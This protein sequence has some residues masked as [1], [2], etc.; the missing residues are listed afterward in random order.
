MLAPGLD[1]FRA[2]PGSA[3]P[4]LCSRCPR[5]PTYMHAYAESNGV[6]TLLASSSSTF[7]ME[8]RSLRSR[9][10]RT[11]RHP[12]QP[13]WWTRGILSGSGSGSSHLAIPRGLFS[14]LDRRLIVAAQDG[15]HKIDSAVL[16]K[17][18]RS[19]ACT[20]PT[21]NPSST[22]CSALCRCTRGCMSP[23]SRSSPTP[24]T[25]RRPRR[26]PDR[27]PTRRGGCPYSIRRAVATAIKVRIVGALRAIP[28]G[29]P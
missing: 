27:T 23:S 19:L 5:P 8:L 9:A 26:P 18:P 3:R 12:P 6:L 2:R 15:S 14:D 21:A 28:T 13:S 16:N 29:K 4:P 11:P 7:R 25:R 1:S 10:A 24:T 17:P 22:V 20:A